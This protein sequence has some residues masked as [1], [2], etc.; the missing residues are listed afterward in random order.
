MK[1]NHKPIF[2]AAFS[3]VGFIGPLHAQKKVT[4]QSLYWVRYYGK[5]KLSDNWGIN[6]EFEDRRFFKDNRQ[7]N[8]VLPRVAVE[9]KLGAGWAAGAGFTYYTAANPADP[10]KDVQVTVPELRPHQYL[11]S[12]QKI[13]DL[14]IS[15]RFQVEERWIHNSS[16]TELTPGYKFQGRFRYQLQA[17][18]PLV[19]RPTAAGSLAVKAADEILLNFGHSIVANTFDQNRVYVGLNYGISE[20][21]QV[22]LG[23]LNWFQER[24]SGD[25]YYARDNV[26]LTIYH[27]IKFY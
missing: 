14:G 19:K 2:W 21:V 26:R 24:S 17:Q 23:Y 15:H 11:T 20:Q 8:A 12:G 5:Y 18:Y 4:H 25:Q 10:T 3:L 22:E 27:S 1:I 6:L 16:A 13:G 7:L 9:R